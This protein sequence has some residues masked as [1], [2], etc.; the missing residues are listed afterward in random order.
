MTLY[1]AYCVDQD[2]HFI[3]ANDIVADDDKAA[4][5]AAG[6]FLGA[7]DIEIWERDR[8]VMRL[9]GLNSV[10]DEAERQLHGV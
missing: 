10:R 3:K 8:K 2:G 9:G 4:I 1:R 5:F 6:G 7:H